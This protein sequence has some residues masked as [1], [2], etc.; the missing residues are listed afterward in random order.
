MDE[1]LEPQRILLVDDQALVREAVAMLL[2]IDCH[3]VV[4]ACD[5]ADA[6]K[7][8]QSGAFDVVITDYAMPG[9]TGDQL[10]SAIRER[11]ALQPII[12]L[13]AHASMLD[14][15]G[16]SLAAIDLVVPKPVTTSTLR[17]ALAK[18]LEKKTSTRTEAS[19]G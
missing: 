16:A 9:M 3:K 6:L 15:M 19:T 4:T 12:L 1:P 7:Q 5:G 2:E 14:A 8:F 10:A 11:N 17:E 18:V 13:T